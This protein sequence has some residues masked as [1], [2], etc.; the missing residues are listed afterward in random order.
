[1]IQSAFLNLYKFGNSF[2][3]FI[4]DFISYPSAYIQTGR[5]AYVKITPG[6]AVQ[7]YGFESNYVDQVNDLVN[8]IKLATDI[9][10]NLYGTD[11]KILKRRLKKLLAIYDCA[12][13]IVSLKEVFDLFILMTV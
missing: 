9:N 11:V 10:G 13:Y 5:F 4:M 1:M 2:I 6:M 12:D 7:L 3:H 8:D